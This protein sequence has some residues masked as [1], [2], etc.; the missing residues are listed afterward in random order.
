MHA[1][2]S[3]E[4]TARP[5]PGRP[6]DGLAAIIVR[7]LDDAG[8][9][10]DV[11][12]AAARVCIDQ[13][14]ALLRAERDSK[15]QPPPRDGGPGTRSG[16]APWQIR[17]VKAHVEA[18]L[19]ATVRARDLAALSRLSASYFATAFKRSFG[20]S[21]RTYL[22]RRRLERAQDMMLTTDHPLSFIALACGFADQAHLSRRFRQSTGGSPSAWRRAR[23]QQIG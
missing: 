16:L 8:K 20:E 22:V 2:L 3:S 17:R 5:A 23:Y 4:S 12:R 19:H 14:S 9:A 10:L 11:D 1:M 15:D 6:P 21:P 13:A 7:L 18:H